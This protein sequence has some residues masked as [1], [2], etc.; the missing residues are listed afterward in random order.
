VFD[1]IA[2]DW[3]TKRCGLALG[4]TKSLI[5]LPYSKPLFSEDLESIVNEILSDN[6]GIKLILFGIPSNAKNGETQTSNKI[7][8]VVEQFKTRFNC[9]IITIDER[10]STKDATSLLKDSNGQTPNKHDINHIS[11]HVLLMKYL[12]TQN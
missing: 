10:F 2:I 9:E 7:K 4:D 11:A 1:I 6:T 3:G 12:E 5:S 8:T